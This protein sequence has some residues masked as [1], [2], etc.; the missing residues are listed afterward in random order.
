MKFKILILFVLSSFIQIV[1]QA[2]NKINY[3]TVVRNNK[4]QVLVNGQITFEISLVQGNAN[5][6]VLYQERH[7]ANT[8]Q[9]GLAS[10]QVGNGVPLFGNFQSINWNNVPIFIRSKVDLFGNN[11]FLL[12]GVMQLVSSPYSIYANEVHYDSL[13]NAPSLAQLANIKDL[14][15]IEDLTSKFD[16]AAKDID[17]NNYETVKIGNQVWF[18][19]D[20]RTTHFNDG[21]PIKNDLSDTAWGFRSGFLAE[22]PYAAYCFLNNDATVKFPY[23]GALYNFEAVTTNKLCP[24]GYKVPSVL[25][26]KILLHTLGGDSSKFSIKTAGSI[27]PNPSVSIA[28][29]Q[30]SF[31]SGASNASGFSANVLSGYRLPSAGGGFYSSDVMVVASYHTSDVVLNSIVP[32]KFSVRTDGVL[33]NTRPLPPLNTDLRNGGAPVRCLKN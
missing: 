13:Y 4:G 5:G 10:L 15:A 30:L 23:R 14:E 7:I 16:F 17:G 32:L 31:M 9:D 28:L 29:S 22:A 24:V 27:D 20:L 21:T 3:Q 6:V 26:Y 33:L 8:N 19:Q 11:T 12:E 25:D 2:P 18:A 1:A